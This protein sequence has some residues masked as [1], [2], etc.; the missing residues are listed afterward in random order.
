MLGYWDEMHALERRVDELMRT[1]FGTR[2]MVGRHPFVPPIDVYE[3]K[4]DLVVHAELPGLD[5]VKDVKVYIEDGALVITGERLQKE[6][7]DEK[8]LYRME[9]SYGA[10][11]RRVA[12]PEG[13]DEDTIR[14][15]YK[16]GVLEVV[17]PKAAKQIEAPK[18]KEIPIH[19]GKPVKAA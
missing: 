18:A 6:E 15:D 14:A 16:E 5:P 4:G 3:R 11:T 12:L 10:F 17:V 7:V 2:T 19:T 8:D 13:I 1:F 9:T